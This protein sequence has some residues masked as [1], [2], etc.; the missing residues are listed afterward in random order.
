MEADLVSYFDSL[1]RTELEKMLQI[2]GGADGS[3]L[4]LIGKCLH[5]GVLDGSQY[6]EPR[7][8][9]TVQGSGLSPLLGNIY[10]HYALDVWF[11]R[12][13]KPR[14]RGKA[15]LLRY[16]DDF[17]ITFEHQ[18]DAER[19]MDVLPKRMGRFGLTLHPGQ[20]PVCCRSGDRRRGSKTAKVQPPSTSSASRCTGAEPRPGRW[21]MWC[22]TR[23]ARLQRTF[24]SIADWCRRNRH[25][26]V[27]VQHR[28]LTRRIQGHYNYFGISGNFRCLLLVDEAAKRSWYLKGNRSRGGEGIGRPRFAAGG[29]DAWWRK[30]TSPGGGA[31]VA[32]WGSCGSEDA[33]NWWRVC[34]NWKQK[35][36]SFGSRSAT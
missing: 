25:E 2:R 29:P 8:R 4:R 1:D 13:V 33:P 20:D 11:E 22:K 31:R 5:V 28:A 27:E 16:V 14:L 15:T 36:L 18:D 21:G 32:M 9:G 3:L 19:V 23:S 10:L 35:T 17:I 26:P 30:L 24:K 12:E 6:T 7:R 34:G